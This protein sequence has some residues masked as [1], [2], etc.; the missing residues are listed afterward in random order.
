MS[1]TENLVLVGRSEKI[2]SILITIDKGETFCHLR[3][4]D[5]SEK[6]SVGSLSAG[7]KLFQ[8]LTRKNKK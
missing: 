2:E 5:F 4:G 6:F 7:T 1:L 8:H 3:N